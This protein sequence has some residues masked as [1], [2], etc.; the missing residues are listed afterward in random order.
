M[1]RWFSERLITPAGTRD[2]VRDD[3]DTYQKDGISKPALQTLND[4]YLIRTTPRGNDLWFEL[5]HDRLISPIVTANQRWL[6]TYENPLLIP[7]RVW[8]QSGRPLTLLLRG[9][10]LTQAQH[11]AEECPDELLPEE[12]ELLA[13]S[14][15][16]ARQRRARLIAIAG[17]WW[18]GAFCSC[19]CCVPSSRTRNK[20]ELPTSGPRSH[21]L[22]K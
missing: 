8:A 4:A 10:L 11:Y 6:L 17:D 5:A 21:W 18:L 14:M 20:C 12:Q 13:L 19:Y 2:L 9:G 22:V 16:S 15:Q 1:R 3:D 7:T